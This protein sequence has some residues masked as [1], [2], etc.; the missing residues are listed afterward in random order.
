MSDFLV[1]QGVPR[2]ALILED[3]SRTTY[4]NAVECRGRLGRRPPG[5]VILVTE[6]T[7]MERSLRCFQK[8]GID[9]V[10]AACHYQATRFRTSLRAF[11][12]SAAA[13]QTC[14][15]VTH[16]WVGMVIYWIRGQI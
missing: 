1:A 7:H 11:L 5:A 3:A 6:A 13:A 16:E 2:T 9:V 15:D 4:E 14:L 8:Q 10:P 12:P